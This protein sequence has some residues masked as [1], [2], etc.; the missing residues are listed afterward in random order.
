M[1]PVDQPD[2]DREPLLNCEQ[3]EIADAKLYR[4]LLNHE[5]PEGK[6]KARFYELIGYT[7]DN[8]EQLQADLL[9]LACSGSVTQ[10]KPNRIGSKYVVVGS[11][12]APNGKRYNILSIWAV[13]SPDE[14]PRL[15][16]AYPTN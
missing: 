4:Y 16:I 8:G 2:A 7:L 14:K 6:S 11:I 13:E 10:I 5:H 9:W 15:I 1:Q 3:A 12:D